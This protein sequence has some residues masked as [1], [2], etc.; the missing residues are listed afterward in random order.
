MSSGASEWDSQFRRVEDLISHGMKLINEHLADGV[1]KDNLSEQMKQCEAKMNRIAKDR[2]QHEMAVNKVRD[3]I[4]SSSDG[5]QKPIDVQK[6]QYSLC[7]IR[8]VY[9]PCKTHFGQV[10]N[11]NARW[12]PCRIKRFANFVQAKCH[13]CS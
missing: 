9:P 3:Q 2:V 11:F 8:T 7:P 12:R 1:E 5:K 10:R 4:Q 6:V 13:K